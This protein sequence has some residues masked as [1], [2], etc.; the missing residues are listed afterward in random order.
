[1]I[2][3]VDATFNFEHFRG[4]NDTFE[5]RTSGRSMSRSWWPI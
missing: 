3:E 1:M 5:V 4:W 2:L